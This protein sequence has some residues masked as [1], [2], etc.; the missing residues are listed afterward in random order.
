MR[1]E[2][3]TFISCTKVS[4]FLKGTFAEETSSDKDAQCIFPF[5]NSWFYFNWQEWVYHL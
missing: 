1:H 5:S 3:K 2:D 4:V